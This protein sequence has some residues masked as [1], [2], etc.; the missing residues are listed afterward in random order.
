MKNNINLCI[1]DMDG[2][3]IDSQEFIV[4]A[5]E[6]TLAKHGLTVPTRAEIIK[7]IGR[8]LDIDYKNI[9]GL[10]DTTDLCA[11]HR[12]F[13]NNKQDLLKAFPN[14]AET[15]KEL[16][17]RGIKIVI[18]TNRS[19]ITSL[20]S[21]ESTGVGMYA[22]LILSKEDVK[23]PKPDSECI[24]KSME[25]FSVGPTETIMI[26]NTY[27]DIETGKNAGVKTVG[28]SFGLGG[29]EIRKSNPDFVVDDF[30]EI[31]QLI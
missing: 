18:A 30:K 14:V 23:N 19:K 28:V 7:Q 1:F 5:F 25:H 31:L 15:L 12:E 24:I 2:T 9:T 29:E 4:S 17:N 10:S 26:G 3:L 8:P 13:Q 22:D 27:I 6:Y 20:A 16:K 11:T 21:L